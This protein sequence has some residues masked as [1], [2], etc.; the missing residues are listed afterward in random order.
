MVFHPGSSYSRILIG[1]AK[2]VLRRSLH[3]VQRAIARRF[4]KR[5][6][7]GRNYYRLLQ[8][9]LSFGSGVLAS[10]VSLDVAYLVVEKDLPVLEKSLQ[11]VRHYLRHPLKAIHVIS[12]HSEPIREFCRRH[13]CEWLDEAHVL[14]IGPEALALTVKGLDR[15]GWLLQQLIKLSLDRISGHGRIY[16]L[17][18]DTVL[19]SPQVFER[20]GRTVL[21][22]SDELHRPYRAAHA[23]LLGA[24]P[25]QPFSLVAHQMVF[26]AAQ[27]AQLRAEIERRHPGVPW[28]RAVRQACVTGAVSGFSEFE[29]YGN[30]V[31]SRAP[32]TVTFEYWFNR[33]LPRRSLARCAEYQRRWAGAVRSISFHSHSD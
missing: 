27:L 24:E 19:C 20:D 22:V 1:S 16:A 30:W 25:A 4:P 33:S 29:T 15:S 17:D 18:A 7:S 32:E 2:R 9:P 3:A 14:G 21:L 5:I 23:T 13:R 8:R 31:S 10:G 11:S 12:P 26:E 6:G 28:W